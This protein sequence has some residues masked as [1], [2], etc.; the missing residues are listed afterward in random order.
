M[1]FDEF[2]PSASRKNNSKELEELW[3]TTAEENIQNEPKEGEENLN[4]D[5][6]HL[7]SLPIAKIEDDPSHQ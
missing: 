6:V 4:D 2:P 1:I 5:V 7:E 3:K